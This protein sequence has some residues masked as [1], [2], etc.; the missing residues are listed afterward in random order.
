KLSDKFFKSFFL[1]F[2]FKC[3][4]CTV[5]FHHET[6]PIIICKLFSNR[7]IPFMIPKGA[8]HISGNMETVNDECRIVS[9]IFPAGCNPL[10]PIAV[11]Y[12]M[13]LGWIIHVSVHYILLEFFPVGKLP[14]MNKMT[15]LL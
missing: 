14:L 2:V 10:S 8:L 6:F 15:F 4:N 11:N 5:Q 1:F 7:T 12:E 13:M 9:E 3:T